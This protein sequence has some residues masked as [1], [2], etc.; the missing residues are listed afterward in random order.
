LFCNDAA[1][2][3]IYTLS[4]P[5]ALPSCVRSTLV[6]SGWATAVLLDIDVLRKQSSCPARC[7]L[8][9]GKPLSQSGRAVDGWVPW[10]LQACYGGF[11]L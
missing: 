11:G 8:L 5:Y 9:V 7:P 4:L 6:G 1:T 3:E 10:L 2:T